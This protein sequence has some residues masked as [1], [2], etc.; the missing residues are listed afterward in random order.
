MSI[1]YSGA[2]LEALLNEAAY[3]AISSKRYVII[4]SDLIKS[5]NRMK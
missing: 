3:S 5:F 2:D 4:D 1:N